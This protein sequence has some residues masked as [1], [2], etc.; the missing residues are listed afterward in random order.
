MPDASLCHLLLCV[1]T[2]SEVLGETRPAW[3]AERRRDARA[4]GHCG[5]RRELFIAD[6]F[7]ATSVE[8]IAQ[9]AGISVRTVYRHCEAKEGHPDGGCSPP[10]FETR[11]EPRRPPVDG[12]RGDRRARGVRRVCA[13]GPCTPPSSPRATSSSS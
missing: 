11:G 13:S 1:K 2:H 5:G 6:G 4:H 10:A 7:D 8:D 12:V 3:L 9:G